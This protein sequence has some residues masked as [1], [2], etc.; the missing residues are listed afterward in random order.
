MASPPSSP[1]L[2]PTAISEDFAPLP[3]LKEKGNAQLDFDG[4]LPAPIKVHE[5]VRTG[6]GGQTWP[7]GLLLG[8]HLL[9]YHR[10]KLRDARMFVLPFGESS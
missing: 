10:D 2:D 3:T 6:C 1:E 8:K 5:D 4:L 9:R 7:A